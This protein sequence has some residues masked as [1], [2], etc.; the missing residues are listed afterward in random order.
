MKS[1]SP[2]TSPAYDLLPADIVATI[3]K[4]GETAENPD[5]TFY[6]KWFT[7]DAGFTWYVAEYDPDSGICHGF[8]I[9]QFPEWGSFSVHEI[10][11]IRGALKLPVERDLCFNACPS[12]TIT[13]DY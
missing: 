2:F 8:V 13:R 11:Q 3:P 6:L 10:R 9:G 4:L 1:S 7:P 12:S 5:P